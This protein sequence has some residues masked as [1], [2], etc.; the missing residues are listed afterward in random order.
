MIVR[1]GLLCWC[2]HLGNSCISAQI[3]V[4]GKQTESKPAMKTNT[5]MDGEQR[6]RSKPVKPPGRPRAATY[7]SSLLSHY[8][9]SRPQSKLHQ[10]PIR[11]A[12]SHRI[13]PLLPLIGGS[14]SPK[15]TA[16]NTK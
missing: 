1:V 2:V 4:K 9:E 12:S 16:A 10:A 8:A 14:L 13:A 15:T 7:T 3:R 11:R 6:N 5:S